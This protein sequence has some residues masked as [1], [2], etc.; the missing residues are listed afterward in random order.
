MQ[1]NKE[2]DEEEKKLEP[3]PKRSRKNSEKNG[4]QNI[5]RLSNVSEKINKISIDENVEI[6]LGTTSSSDSNISTVSVS[7]SSA[8]N[9]V[10]VDVENKELTI[11]PQNKTKISDKIIRILNKSDENNEIVTSTPNKNKEVTQTD[12]LLKKYTQNVEK[13]EGEIEYIDVSKLEVPQKEVHNKN[14]NSTVTT[15]NLLEDTQIDEANISS[16]IHLSSIDKTA[17]VAT[18]SNSQQKRKKRSISS[19]TN[20]AKQS[21]KT[22]KLTD[23]NETDPLASIEIKSEP[24]SDQ[25]T[26]EE[27]PKPARSNTIDN[28]TKVIN[29]VAAGFS[30]KTKERN[31]TPK[32]NKA[33]KSFP[34][35]TSKTDVQTTATVSNNNPA[36]P[37]IRIAPTSSSVQS[38]SSKSTSHWSESQNFI[39]QT[40]NQLPPFI[41]ISDIQQTNVV[42]VT[43]QAIPSSSFVIVTNS[44]PNQYLSNVMDEFRTLKD[45]LP[46]AAAKAVS[47]LMCRPPPALKPRPPSAIAQGFEESAPS[48]AGPVTSKLNSVAYR[49]S[50]SISNSRND[51]I[52]IVV[53]WPIISVVC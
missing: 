4:E 23:Q 40:S 26:T 17:A 53:R 39:P 29:D 41:R 33:R 43:T 2:E 5:R 27:T 16:I 31:N 19:E 13:K 35:P 20:E 1:D 21:N 50:N 47:E 48:A 46:E 44:T 24:Y 45:V 14:E 49:V 3:T 30:A 10:Q 22:I 12:L 51:A 32:Q 38:I 36:P 8:K 42:N 34:A 37:L 7:D 11:S 52:G 6:T 18:D 15:G 9:V 28:V 25:E